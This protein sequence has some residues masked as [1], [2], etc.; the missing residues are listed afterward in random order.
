MKKNLR[1][2][3]VTKLSWSQKFVLHISHTTDTQLLRVSPVQY[4]TTKELS[5]TQ[6]NQEIEKGKCFY[7]INLDKS[8]AS[9][10]QQEKS[11]EMAN[12]FQAGLT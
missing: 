9:F 8:L 6:P 5:D 7:K 3:F 12:F 11:F 2:V 4:S 1:I 10:G